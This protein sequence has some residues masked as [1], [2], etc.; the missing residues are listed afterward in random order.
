[1]PKTLRAWLDQ[2]SWP[3]RECSWASNSITVNL[4]SPEINV[5]S[6]PPQGR[7]R[8]LHNTSNLL[9]VFRICWPPHSVV[10]EGHV[11]SIDS[12]IALG[13]VTIHL[14][15]MVR[16]LSEVNLRYLRHYT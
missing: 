6:V 1:M 16:I 13:G 9:S 8:G 11:E 3:S 14:E 15:R 4:L 2:E 5:F 12:K 10:A 7:Q